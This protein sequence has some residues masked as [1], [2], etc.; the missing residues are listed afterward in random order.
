[1]EGFDCEYS[2]KILAVVEEC[3]PVARAISKKKDEERRSSYQFEE[4]TC[5]LCW[6]EY[7]RGY[8]YK[9]KRDKHGQISSKPKKDDK[10]DEVLAKLL[11]DWKKAKEEKVQAGLFD[12][13]GFVK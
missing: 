10:V 1:M 4:V 2:K 3:I 12:E 8:I 11:A 9:H 6:K 7:P 13:E 5:E